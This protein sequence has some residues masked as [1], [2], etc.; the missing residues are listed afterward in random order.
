MLPSPAPAQT[1]A[2]RQPP[3]SRSIEEK[4]ACT[5][6]LKVI[7][8]A[9]EAYKAD[10]KELPNWLSDLVPQYLPDTNVLTCPVCRRT[11]RFE[12]PPLADPKI[13]SSY[14]FEFC[15]LPLTSSNTNVSRHTRR[16]WKERQMELAGPIVPVVRCRHHDPVLN[17]AFDGR[18]YD[19][20][21]SWE[22]LLTNR[23]NPATLTMAR[24]FAGGTNRTARAPAK[25]SVEPGPPPVSQ[26]AAT[27]NTTPVTQSS[28]APPLQISQP[29]PAFASQSNAVRPS[30]GPELPVPAPRPQSVASPP[31]QR[32]Q[33]N[34]ATAPGSNWTPVLLWCGW[35]TAVTVIVCVF[36]ARAR[37]RSLTP[38]K[39]SLLPVR[40]ETRADGAPTCTITISAPSAT[41]SALAELGNPSG[42]RPRLR[43]QTPIKNPAPFRP[44]PPH[45]LRPLQE[46]AREQALQRSS[47]LAHLSQWLK[48]RLVQRLITDRVQLLQNQ[49][50]ATLQI[51]DV[52][53]RLARVERQ[54]KEH[55]RAYEE[56]IADLS[57]ELLAA[58]EENRELIRARIEQVKAEMHAARARAIAEAEREQ[59]TDH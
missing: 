2:V 52:D 10:H 44:M 36:V 57:R 23:L 56:R 11:G 1:N 26:I 13:S 20:P 50:A 30:V 45:D 25:P 21:T 8:S 40:I 17:V 37:R 38:Q 32:D 7:F 29:M 46:A 5:R 4:E 47:F 43:L 12:G 55:T 59:T 16:E 31:P 48:Q 53:Q 9:I 24:M 35:M 54:I 41:S 34:P 28:N 14:L 51:Q 42:G 49:E 15:P 33:G 19:S 6:N 27:T 3:P 22:A 39:Q 58:R 18:I